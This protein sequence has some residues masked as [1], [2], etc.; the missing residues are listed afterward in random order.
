MDLIKHYIVQSITAASSN[1]RLNSQR[2]EVIA[3]LKEVILKSK[4]I[5][6]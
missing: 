4:D 6:Q 1:L 3:M 2:I 5:Q